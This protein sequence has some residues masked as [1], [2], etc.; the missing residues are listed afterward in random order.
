MAKTHSY[1]PVKE[2]SAKRESLPALPVP[3]HTK[4]DGPARQEEA[5]S[6]IGHTPPILQPTN[7]VGLHTYQPQ[8]WIST[9][10][11]LQI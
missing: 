4:G 6:D 8:G 3:F 10:R 5:E 11:G 9:E 7:M 2:G 1:R